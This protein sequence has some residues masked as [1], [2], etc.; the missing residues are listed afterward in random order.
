MSQ[1][2][3]PVRQ[4]G[5]APILIVLILAA[6]G[7]A[8]YLGTKKPSVV[9]TQ[10]VTSQT[11]QPTPA[12]SPAPTG[13]G[14]TATWKT[15]TNTVHK[16]SIKYPNTFKVTFGDETAGVN[17]VDATVSKD[18]QSLPK[19]IKIGV[20]VNQGLTNNFDNIYNTQ[21]GQTIPGEA[22]RGQ[23]VI[24]VR[25]LSFGGYHAA[26]YLIETVPI[27]QTESNFDCIRWIVIKRN[28]DLINLGDHVEMMRPHDCSEFLK[29]R[30]SNIFDQI[31][32]TFKFLD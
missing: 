22:D 27:L 21:S 28:D 14:E 19:N 23:K 2:G 30:P 8:Y 10:V 17:F 4:A 18:E 3:L 29:N 12:A 5:S 6:I 32:S 25:N 15:Y 31:L 9:P 1:K 26:E 16:F 24:K 20:F 7:G 13:A 11:P